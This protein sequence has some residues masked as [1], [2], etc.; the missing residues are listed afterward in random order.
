MMKRLI[1][2]ADD[3][4]LSPEMN[5]GILQAHRHGLVTSASLMVGAPHSAAAIRAA[6]ECPSLSLGIHLQFVQGNALSAPHEVPTLADSDGKLPDSVFMLMLKRPSVADIKHEA[7]TQVE[8]FVTA[9]GYVP[10]FVNT[11]QHAHLL[12]RVLEA[13]LEVSREFGI[14]L[15]RLPEEHQPLRPNRRLRSWLWPV[16][17]GA[18]RLAR[19]AIYRAGLRCPDKML[20]GPESGQM[21]TKT[22]AQLLRTLP[23]GTTELVVHPVTGGSD[24]KALLNPTIRRELDRA[25]VERVAF[26]VL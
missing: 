20:G 9:V 2:T 19:P 11:H 14:C 17:A 16:A 22:L 26:S 7:R 4:G 1:V 25:Q 23:N 24:L 21:T 8:A 6:L 12:P 5:A 18:A 3:L 15:I 10:Q 13:V